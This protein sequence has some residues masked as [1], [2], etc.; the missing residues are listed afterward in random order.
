MAECDVCGKH[1]DMPYECRRCG[2]DFCA[3]HR[4]PE[5]HSCPGLNEWNDPEGVF[6]S[7]MDN[8]QTGRAGSGLFDSL[9]S[10][11][12]LL[13][14]FDGNVSYLFLGIMVVV[15]AFQY[16]IY[17]L[18]GFE[19]VFSDVWRASFVLTAEH[20]E[21]VWTWLTSVFSHGGFTHL[22][23]NGIALFFF[24]PIVE[25][26]IGSKR[27]TALFL[28]SGVLA[29]LGQIALG[30][31]VGDFTGVLGASGAIM[32]IM[33]LLTVLNPDI[34]VLLFFFIPMPIWGLT[35]GYALISVFGAFG[36]FGG[37]IAHMA[38]LLGLVVG[39]VYGKR[40]ED[41]VSLPNQFQFGGGGGGG[42]GGMGGGG[43]GRRRF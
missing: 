34:K 29:G 9:S 28:A 4:L 12:G 40:I 27:F 24:G 37:G 35:L 2:G 19:A 21:Y 41:E 10:G 36:T 33:A 25:R 42:M 11:G 43:G 22:F 38:H 32:A 20:P 31:A 30:L 7:D 13:S 18:L 15:F 23:G 8:K 17:P 1:I 5:N 6:E 16:M 3:E 26:Y 39:F 14:Y